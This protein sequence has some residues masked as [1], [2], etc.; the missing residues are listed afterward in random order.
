MSE[1]LQIE[2]SQQGDKLTMPSTN[3]TGSKRASDDENWERDI[4]NRLAFASLNEQRRRR[5]WR[6][7]F[8]FLLFIYLFLIYA[9]FVESDLRNFITG[10]DEI[11]LTSSQHTALVEI[12]GVIAADAEANAD[13]IVSSLRRAF[14]DHNTAGVIIRIN[15]PGGSPVQAG[16]INDEITRLRE[17]Y[18]EIPIYAVVS[19]ICASGGYYIAAA[20]DK[21][22]ADKASIVG[23]IGVLMNGFGFVEALNKLGIERR[24]LTAGE[25]K[26]FL[27]PYSPMKEEDV[28]H[29]EGLLED[30]HAQFIKVVKQGREKSLKA[31]DKLELLDNPELFSGLVWT[32]EQALEN[33]LVD[34]LGSSSYVAREIIKAE[35]IKDFTSKP[36]YLDRFAERLGAAIANT[37][38][39]ELKLN[40]ATIE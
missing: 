14:K 30:I 33:G 19:D 28:S 35:K 23:S 4:V 12:E 26:G 18:S 10:E 38:S 21:I 15:S 7:F 17:K 6:I 36:N 25:H 39:Q 40:S 5:R 32:G 3:E 37:I 29:I 27:D 16:Y 11:T 22:Y 2:T 20:A 24:L 9:T 34:G 13:T 1:T 8:T 31:Q